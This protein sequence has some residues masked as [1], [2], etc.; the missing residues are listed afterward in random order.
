MR[1]P[2]PQQRTTA[3]DDACFAHFFPL[4]WKRGVFPSEGE[5]T[6][7]NRAAEDKPLKA[8]LAGVRRGPSLVYIYVS[9][10]TSSRPTS[11]TYAK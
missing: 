8:G 3:T 6:V 7:P 2:V 11:T 9:L 5:K 4:I 10:L 1:W